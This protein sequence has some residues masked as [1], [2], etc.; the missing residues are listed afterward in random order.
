M[1]RELPNVLSIAGSDPSGGAGIQADLRTFAALGVY[2]CAVP[3]ALTA[4]NTMGVS[5]IFQVPS[6]FLEQQLDTVFSDVHVAAVKV[7]MLG[8]ADAVRAVAAALRRYRPGFVVL[9]PV[10]RASTGAPLLEPDAIGVLRDE[11]FPL[12][13]V[14]TPNAAETGALLREPLPRVA[15]AAAAAAAAARLGT[16]A[17]CAVL[18]TGVLDD[19][20]EPDRAMSVDVLYHDGKTEE[21]RVPRVESRNTHGTGCTLASAVA[22]YLAL[23]R[24]L[25]SAC[26]AAQQ[27]VARAIAAGS[28]L[29]VGR[30]A[31]PVNQLI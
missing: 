3:A 15:D 6:D 19:R 29:H 5:G 14:I 20:G 2:G 11:L 16:V 28:R 31:G 23:G 21:L 30:G 4:Q 26:A 22:A 25:R 1:T 27:F 7:G 13:T 10:L 9:D 17:R 24:D 8:S 12:A 18:V